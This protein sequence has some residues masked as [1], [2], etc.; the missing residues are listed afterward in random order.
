MKIWTLMPVR[1]I[2]LLALAACDPVTSN[3]DPAAPGAAPPEEL[4]LSCLA[5]ADASEASLQAAYGPDNIVEQTLPGPEGESYVATVLYPNDPQRRLEIVWADDAAK[6]RPASLSVSGANSVW[7][8]PNG[9]SIADDLAR[10]EQLNGRP[11]KLWG[12]G[13]DYGGWVSD[14]SGGAF[15]PANGCMMRVRFEPGTETTTATGDGEF[16]SDDARMRNAAARVSEFGVVFVT[17]ESP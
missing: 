6:T 2:A 14:W 4:D 11:F 7:T 16:Q 17:P 13:W 10:V 8:G 15:A 5:F 3:S 1:A 9:L 12:F